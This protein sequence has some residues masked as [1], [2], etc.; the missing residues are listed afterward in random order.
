VLSHATL[1]PYLR[2]LLRPPVAAGHVLGVGVVGYG[3]FGG[4]GYAHGLACAETEG[5]R[6]VAAVDTVPERL[7]V[8]AEDFA[9]LA[10]YDSVD[11]LAADEDVDVAVVATPPVH[12]AALAEQLLRAGK[13]VVVEKPMCLSVREAD[14]LVS[15]A[16]DAGRTLTVHQSRR[17]D[18]DFRALRCAVDA[19]LL[20]DVFV[21]ETFV[22]GFEH[23]CRAW[24]SE[25][26]VSGG[27]VY[28]WGSH[29][30]D[31]I[32][33]LLGGPPR[34]V[35]CTTHHRVWHDTTNADQLA[36]WMQWDDGRE[37]TFRQ[38][39]VAAIRRPKFYVQG[40]AGTV[41]GHYRLLRDER[42]EPG[43]GHVDSWSHHA[44]APVELTLVRYEGG[45]GLVTTELPL[46]PPAG[47]AFHRNLADHLLLDEPLA[48]P[49]AESRD[50]V[51]VLEAGQRSGRDGGA[52]M[53]LAP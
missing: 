9:D 20:G 28:D 6:L 16:A 8:A 23:P 12:H 1:G 3:A 26:S 43:R 49:P 44:E 25:E 24:H 42:I 33:L 30:V 7:K 11:A 4:M 17:W 13:H 22:G 40:T 41:A 46:R 47:W 14:R 31:W 19:G 27:A 10:T 35:M 53:E 29:H 36:L 18:R 51:R 2:R 50:V 38:S 45:D 5:L 52:I 15:V 39:D 21:V 48:V 32:L 37:A 34:R